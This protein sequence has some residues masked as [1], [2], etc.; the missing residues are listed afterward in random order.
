MCV[1]MCDIRGDRREVVLRERRSKEVAMPVLESL[2]WEFG[3]GACDPYHD[4]EC[5]WCSS[6]LSTAIEL[7]L[8]L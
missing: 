7:V 6:P 2:Y 4:P 5:R 8:V 3:C 1:Y